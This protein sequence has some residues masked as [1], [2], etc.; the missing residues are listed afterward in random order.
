MT[1]ESYH[2][3]DPVVAAHQ[4]LVSWVM[5]V[6]RSKYLE[7]VKPREQLLDEAIVEALLGQTKI[8][9]GDH[10][11]STDLVRVDTTNFYPSCAVALRVRGLLEQPTGEITAVQGGII[12]ETESTSWETSGTG[13]ILQ[14]IDNARRK[15]TPKKQQTARLA[16]NQQVQRFAVSCDPLVVRSEDPEESDTTRRSP[17]T[18]LGPRR[19]SG[20][21]DVAEPFKDRT[22]YSKHFGLENV[23]ALYVEA[24]KH[25]DA[26]SIVETIPVIEAK[27]RQRI[28]EIYLATFVV[29]QFTEFEAY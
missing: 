5:D 11:I 17:F 22:T 13:I 7:E 24:D 23:Y 29:K 12:G 8:Y 21:L 25:P 2:Y 6:G 26:S 1:L 4:E 28:A 27:I 10:D 9:N 18:F 15:N 16:I 3:R 19:I 20:Q 14:A